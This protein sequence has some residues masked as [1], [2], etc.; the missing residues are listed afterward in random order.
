LSAADSWYHEKESAWL[1]RAVAAAEP[2]A[3][4][5]ELFLK[6]AGADEEQ[7]NHR[8]LHGGLRQC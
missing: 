1:Y 5:R 3:R 8:T 2:D 6:L 7:A 4:N